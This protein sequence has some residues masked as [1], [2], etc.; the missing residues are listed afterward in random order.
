MLNIVVKNKFGVKAEKELGYDWE[1]DKEKV[2]LYF[3]CKS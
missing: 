1:S 2:C 3:T